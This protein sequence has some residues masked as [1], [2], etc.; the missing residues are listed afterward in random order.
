MDIIIPASFLI[1]QHGRFF[2]VLMVKL[3]LALFAALAGYDD[4]VKE[5]RWLTDNKVA[6]ALL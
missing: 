4:A 1:Y 3:L 5:T 6:L 2:L